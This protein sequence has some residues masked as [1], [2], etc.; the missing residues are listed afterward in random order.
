VDSRGNVYVG[1]NCYQDE[2]PLPH[3]IQQEVVELNASGVFR[4]GLLGNNPYVPIQPGEQSF[5][6]VNSVAV[7]ARDNLYVGSSAIRNAQGDF[8]SGILEYAEGPSLLTIYRLPGNSAPTGIAFDG[9]N[10]LYAAVSNRVL[11]YVP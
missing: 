7:D 6:T 2:C 1:A 11:R 5:V 8:Y 10:A 3:G 4:A 9:R